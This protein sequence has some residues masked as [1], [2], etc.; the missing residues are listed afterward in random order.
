[1]VVLVDFQDKAYSPIIV[2]L[3]S[4]I[5]SIFFDLISLFFSFLFFFL[6]NEEKYD[7]GYITYHIT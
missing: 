1:M 6:D 5:L 3:N 4:D 2:C 7:C